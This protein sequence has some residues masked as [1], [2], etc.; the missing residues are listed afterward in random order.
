MGNGGAMRT[1]LLANRE[2]AVGKTLVAPTLASALARRG[3]RVALA[4]ADRQRPA[5]LAH[6]EGLSA[7]TPSQIGSV[8]FDAAEAAEAAAAR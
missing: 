4:D 6:A 1:V 8:P 7:S 3:E 2:G 5:R